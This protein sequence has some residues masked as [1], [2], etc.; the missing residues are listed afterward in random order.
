MARLSRYVIDIVILFV[1][2]VLPSCPELLIHPWIP[3]QPAN[4]L[5]KGFS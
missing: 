5:N 1:H 4:N 3:T 2:N